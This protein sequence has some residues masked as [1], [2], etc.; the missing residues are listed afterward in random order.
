VSDTS[1]PKVGYKNPPVEHR[2]KKGERRNPKGRPPKAQR[3]FLPTQ[4]VRDVLSITEEE[5]T[6]R[7]PRGTKKIATIEALMRRLVQRALE[8]HGPSLRYA[9]ELHAEAVRQHR[10]RFADFFAFIEMVEHSDI[11]KPVRP[12]N[13]PFNRKFINDL[14]KKTRRT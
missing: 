11:E 14:R 12:E 3:S 13:E 1:K 2:I 5:R 9:I 6:V 4:T 10:D 8:G 7:T